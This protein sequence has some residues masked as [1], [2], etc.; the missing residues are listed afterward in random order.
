MAGLD[1]KAFFTEK[2]RAPRLERVDIPELGGTVVMKGL[3][4][5]KRDEFERSIRKPNGE[6]RPNLRARLVV[7]CA[8]G[9]A[10][11]EQSVA[12][13]ERLFTDNDIQGVGGMRVDILQRMF[14]AAQRVCGISD[15]DLR[16]LGEDSELAD[17]TGSSSSS[18]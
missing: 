3:T 16:E 15:E 2:A 11:D 8:H 12:A 5:T 4:G 13:G 6:L 18:H 7:L 17:G 10:G 1:R 14:D 9:D